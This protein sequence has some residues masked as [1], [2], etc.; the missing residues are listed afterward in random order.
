MRKLMVVL[1]LVVTFGI[2]S[3]ASADQTSHV[4]GFVSDSSN[5]IMDFDNHLYLPIVMGGYLPSFCDSVTEI[6]Q[7]ECEGLA[8]LYNSTDGAEWHNKTGWLQSKDPCSWYGVHCGISSNNVSSIDLIDNNLQGSLPPELGNF[9]SLR[10]LWLYYNQL[11][12]AI[13][14]ELGTLSSLLGLYLHDN[15]LTGAIPPELGNLTNLAYLNLGY[16]LLTGSIPPELGNLPN[17]QA[18]S[19]ESTHL[20]GSLPPEFGNLSKLENLY[21]NSNQLSGSIPPELG[22]LTNLGVLHLDNNQLGGPVPDS[23]RNLINLMTLR[24]ND[25]DPSLCISTTELLAFFNSVPYYL[26]PGTLCTP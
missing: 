25:N 26:G 3:I 10:F 18:L 13:P 7:I 24:L 15:Q 1:L 6:P 4:G 19:L 21:L 16:N 12:G 2:T 8:A 22:Y 20:T 11:S 23:L 5:E 14:P 17:L 9:S